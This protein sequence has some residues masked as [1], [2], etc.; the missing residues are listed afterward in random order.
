MAADSMVAGDAAHRRLLDSL[1]SAL[2]GGA[3]PGELD[4]FGAEDCRAAAEFIAGCAARRPRGTALVRLELTGTRLGQ[5]RM[6]ICIAND[7]MPFLVDSVAQAIAA[8]GLIIH[9]LLHP[10]VCVTRDRKGGLIAIEPLCDDKDRRES[11]MYIEVDRAD[12]KSRAELVAELHRV[13]ANVR[14]A[15][16]DWRAMQENMHAQA[17]AVA[18]GEG[19]A[20]LHWLA[21]GAMTLLGYEVERPR[22]EARPSGSASCG[23]PT[24]R[25]TRAAARARSAIS[26]RAGRCRCSPRPICARRST[27]GCRST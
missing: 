7:D 24:I 27:A 25:P 2:C 18:D 11:I 3:L 16:T 22:Q 9:R 8:R 6:R 14:A 26:S 15:V 17:E 4:D 13:L 23:F 21:D 20:L 12:A 5:R 1:A 19:K 10:V